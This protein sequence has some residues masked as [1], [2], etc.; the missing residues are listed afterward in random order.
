M[1]NVFYDS[2]WLVHSIPKLTPSL[3]R[4]FHAVSITARAQ[5]EHNWRLSSQADRFSR[6]LSKD[7]PR[8][9]RE[10]E[11]EQLGDFRQCTWTT[12]HR[13]V[14]EEDDHSHSSARAGAKR[15]KNIREDDDQAQQ[16]EGIVITLVYEKK[17]Y[18]FVLYTALSKSSTSK[19]NR[20][21][22]TTSQDTSTKESNQATLLLSKSSPAAL[23]ALTEYLCDTFS[24][25]HGIHP[26]KL[27]ASL[28]QTSTE[29]YLSSVYA[30]LHTD[31]GETQTAQ[32]RDFANQLF[33]S[34]VGTIKLT[35]SFSAPVV[36]P[37][38]K[39]LEIG[40]PPET[41]LMMCRQFRR[42]SETK[43]HGVDSES[44]EA[45]ASFMGL[46]A[47][48]VLEKTGLSIPVRAVDKT[49]EATIREFRDQADCVEIN[50]HDQASNPP[51]MR[52]TRVTTASYALSMDSRLKF[53]SRAV[54]LVED[55]EGGE[56]DCVRRANR[57]LLHA[58]LNEAR[59]QARE[60]G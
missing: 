40:I 46:L 7:R 55:R 4:L 52:I 56:G 57:D 37:K 6:S 26:L 28:L 19:R 38:L 51:A 25:D 47:G 53:V 31:L 9:E 3:S 43:D 16:S 10:E 2:S 45:K 33:K 32:S 60:E 34:I 29:Q 30:S 39:S 44:A 1:D 11:K 13:T 12:L 18:K 15:K 24:L 20:T 50:G 54:D 27:P 42:K 21:A 36:A 23:K 41:A 22:F 8:Y 49:T 48:R 58:V 59:R 5:G 14:N 17:T 35:V